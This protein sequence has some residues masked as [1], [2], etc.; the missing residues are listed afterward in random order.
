MKH[1]IIS[2]EEFD[3]IFDEGNEDIIQYLDD[4]SWRLSEGNEVVADVS[5]PVTLIERVDKEAENEGVSR[6]EMVVRMLSE[7]FKKVA[8]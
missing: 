6:R 1:K 3:R 8:M 2:A 4:D 7:Y 5:L